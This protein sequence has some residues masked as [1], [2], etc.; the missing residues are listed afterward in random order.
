MSE[1]F[2][3]RSKGWWKVGEKRRK[4]TMGESKLLIQQQEA[5]PQRWYKKK[6]HLEAAGRARDGAKL[7][8]RGVL[9]VAIVGWFWASSGPS[10]WAGWGWCSSHLW[11]KPSYAAAV[12]LNCQT[13]NL[14]SRLRPRRLTALLSVIQ[15]S[16]LPGND[17]GLRAR[18]RSGCR[19]RTQRG[20]S[21]APFWQ[22]SA[23]DTCRWL[24]HTKHTQLPTKHTMGLD[25]QVLE[26]HYTHLAT[27]CILH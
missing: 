7:P 25:C 11:L 8:L 24:L 18:G 21:S 1:S 12:A 5:Q 20:F 26:D 13:R 14:P 27:H 16:R 9:N 3:C 19:E 17:S 15:W 4:I 6:N 2:E 10:G 22:S 23:P